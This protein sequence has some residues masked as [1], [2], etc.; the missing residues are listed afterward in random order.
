MVSESTSETKAR[1]KPRLWSGRLKKG[2]RFPKGVKAFPLP[3]PGGCVASFRVYRLQKRKAAPR[4]AAEDHNT[5]LQDLKARA[6]APRVGSAMSLVA[7]GS[8]FRRVKGGMVSRKR[9]ILVRFEEKRTKK[10]MKRVVGRRVKTNWVV[11][12]RRRR[13][14]IAVASFTRLPAGVQS[15]AHF[16]GLLRKWS[17]PKGRQKH[18]KAVVLR[19]AQGGVMALF[20]IKRRTEPNVDRVRFASVEEVDPGKRDLNGSIKLLKR[21]LPGK[22]FECLDTS[23]EAITTAEFDIRMLRE[24]HRAVSIRPK[25]HHVDGKKR[26]TTDR[27][28][29]YPIN[30]MCP[31]AFPAESMPVRKCKEQLAAVLRLVASLDFEAETEFERPS[32]ASGTYV[33]PRLKVVRYR[34][35]ALGTRIAAT[36]NINY[37]AAYRA[38]EK[39]VELGF[40]EDDG[41]RRE[42]RAPSMTHYAKRYIVTEKLLKGLQE[43][44]EREK[45]KREEQEAKLRSKSRG[46]T[47]D[48]SVF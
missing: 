29:P 15:W 40:L 13:T 34:V 48:D 19:D 18:P 11:A 27:A 9:R 23:Y 6:A 21:L 43:G 22:W 47:P 42:V 45:K 39:L 1:Q 46:H 4:P 36:L 14:S 26:S 33:V 17:A 24:W 10:E 20:A 16:E 32:E 38:L 41:E 3:L 5:F 31:E 35:E 28:T 7:A 25:L 30:L 12:Y 44:V 2:R 37:R 8:M